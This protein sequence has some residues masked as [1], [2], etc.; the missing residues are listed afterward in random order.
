MNLRTVALTSLFTASF[1]A[2]GR[3][4]LGDYP[5]LLPDHS[6]GSNGSNGSAPSTGT[7]GGNATGGSEPAGG[8]GGS[9]GAVAGQASGGEE[10]SESGGQPAEGAAGGVAGEAGDDSAP[11]AE[12]RSCRGSLDPCRM[13]G[14][15]CCA[16]GYVSGGEFVR[17]GIKDDEPPAVLNHVSSF[18]LGI[19]EV[20]VGRFQAF[21][22]DYDAWRATG[23]PRAGDGRHPLVPGSGWRPEWLRHRG[24]PPESYGLGVDRAEVQDEVAHCFGIPFSTDDWHQPVNCVSFYEAEAFCI[25]DGGRLPT[26]LEWEYAAVGGKNNWPYPWGF[27]EPNLL[28]AM[29]GCATTLNSPCN[30]PPVGSYASGAG[31]F[32]QLDLAGSLAEWTFDALGDP[33]PTPCNDCATVEQRH[34]QN[35]RHV[36]G[37]NWTSDVTQIVPTSSIAMEARLHL[38]MHGIRCAYDT[39]V[40]R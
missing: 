24:D 30:I 11:H 13:D 10:S 31:L 34:V 35:P 26:E 3:L 40:E 23:A 36:R 32:G 4:D 19:Y 8:A 22:D 2:C 37:G 5:E 28:M 29:Y 6:H 16:V 7:M 27:A 38:P 17:G 9:S 18:Y 33:Y 21:L 12:K 1:A 39:D 15:S 25:W 20:T 14:Q